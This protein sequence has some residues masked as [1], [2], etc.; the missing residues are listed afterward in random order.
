[1]HPEIKKTLVKSNENGKNG[2]DNTTSEE[3]K[4]QRRAMRLIHLQ[5][6]GILTSIKT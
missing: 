6:K 3:A 5:A 2:N 4:Y 1:M